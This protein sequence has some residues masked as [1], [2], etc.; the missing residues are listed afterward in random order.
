MPLPASAPYAASKYAVVGLSHSLRTEAARLG[1]G[2]SVVCPAAVETPIFERGE[3][4][5]LD[6]KA[7]LS[8]RPGAVMQPSACAKSILRGIER[9][10]ATIT[11]GVSAVLWR[12]YRFLPAMWNA[13]ARRL[14]AKFA[15]FTTTPAPQVVTSGFFAR[16]SARTTEVRS[17]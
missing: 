1:I 12:V 14:G 10:R 11:P 2:V 5:G 8:A 17:A 6:P 4:V 13:M 16:K 15:T 9:N 7:V 3:Y